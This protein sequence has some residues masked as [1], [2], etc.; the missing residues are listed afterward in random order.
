MAEKRRR[1]AELKTTKTAFKIFERCVAC[2]QAL[3]LLRGRRCLNTSHDILD[4]YNVVN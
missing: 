4:V 2:S 1:N 3:Q